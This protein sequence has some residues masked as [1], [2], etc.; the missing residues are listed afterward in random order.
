MESE[1]ADIL[2][3]KHDFI[4]KPLEPGIDLS[5][6]CS[7]FPTYTIFL[8]VLALEYDFAKITKTYLIIREK[9]NKVIA[10]FL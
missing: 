8:Q 5:G 4:V 6:F 3:H 9:D 10:F 1:R 7:E 2:S